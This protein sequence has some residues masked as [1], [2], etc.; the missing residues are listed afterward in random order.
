MAREIKIELLP[1][2]RAAIL[3]A[4]F[5]VD[6]EVQVQL[7][8]HASN[9]NVETIIFSGADVH[10]LAGDLNHA[11]VK[12][13]CRDEGIIELSDRFDYINDTSDGSLDRWH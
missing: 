7:E 6:D 2:E 4:N 9:P 10:L 12:R 11:I 1:H 8:A 3:R 5:Y 13:G